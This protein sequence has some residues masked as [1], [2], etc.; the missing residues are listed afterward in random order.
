MIDD[1]IEHAELLIS[2]G[3]ND[4]ALALYD[5]VIA[6]A[7]PDSF[8]YSRRGLLRRLSGDF[9]GAENDFSAA[10]KLSPDDAG[11]YCDRGATL[12]HRMST[13][14][15][16][17]ATDKSNLLTEILTDYNASLERDPSNSNAWL[18]IIETELLLH[19]WDAAISHY[20]QCR[21]HMW[22]KE[23]SLIR[24]W[25]GCLSLCL[26]GEDVNNEDMAPLY[27]KTIRL[28]RNAWCVAEIDNLIDELKS[29]HD[30]AGKI[31]LAMVIHQNFLGHF[32]ENPIRME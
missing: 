14:R 29:I 30:M 26:A 6:S 23:Y 12:A 28:N 21:A 22:N 8:L 1:M 4:R 5:Q 18:A 15:N 7:A 25:L 13:T 9:D 32:D 20:A 24:A 19:E 31:Y 10:I 2:S 17:G 27:N 11:L 16:I 3:E